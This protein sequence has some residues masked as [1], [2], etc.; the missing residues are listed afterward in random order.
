MNYEVPVQKLRKVCNP[1]EFDFSTTDAVEPLVGIVGQERALRALQLG[2]SMENEGFNIYVVGWPGTGRTGAVMSF[3]DGAAKAKP[4][5]PDW[6]Y[7]HN[8]VDPYYPKAIRLPP[9]QARQFSHDVHA[10]LSEMRV[11]IPLALESEQYTQKHEAVQGAL[12]EQRQAIFAAA[13]QAA[14]RRGFVLQTSPQGVALVPLKN[15]R[16]MTEEEFAALGEEQRREITSRRML[17]ESELGVAMKQDRLAEKRA[18][19]QLQELEREAALSAVRPLVEELKAKYQ[20]STDVVAYLIAVQDSVR[21]NLSAFRVQEQGKPA[22]PDSGA[23]AAALWHRYEVNVMVDNAE[24]Q[25]A[26]VLIELNVT[27]NN[28]FGRIEREAEF[29]SLVTDFTMLK[30]GALHRAN[31]G[32]IV[33]P[34]EGLLANPLAWDGLKRALRSRQIS[35]EDVAEQISAVPVKSV[36]PEPIPLKVKVILIGDPTSYYF[37]QQSDP[38]LA[39]LFKVKAHFDVR[40]ERNPENV[41]AYV[42]FFSAL[43]RKENL[44]PLQRDAAARLIEQGSLLAEDQEQLST[45]FA[46]IADILREA[47]LYARQDNAV[48]VKREHVQRAIDERA[49]RSDALQERIREEMLKGT[50]LIDTDA[51]LVGQVNGLSVLSQG[52]YEFGY[53]TRISATVGQGRDGVL[54]LDREA[55][56]DGPVHTKGV[57]TLGGYLTHKYAHDKPLTLSAHLTFEQSYDEVE[58]DSASSSELYALLS[59]LAELPIRQGIAV[60]GSVN[61]YGQV[62]AIGA[63]N[64]KVEGFFDL[65]KA[66]GLTGRHGVIIPNSNVRNLMLKEELVAAVQNGMFHVYAVENV[67]QGV[68]LLTGVEAGTRGTDGQYP[69]GT[70]HAK[71][72][73]RLR[74]LVKGIERFGKDKT[75]EKDRKRRERSR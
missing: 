74:A 28:L 2:L 20:A 43:C 36:R 23:G 18:G 29:G 41:R 75:D 39:E 3:L 1:Q 47:D 22:T 64:A 58:G 40:M 49:H 71:V 37:L 52:D 72:D 19:E 25:G 4:T 12:N 51:E 35:I 15:G 34:V 38:D 14:Q 44:R 69:A 73:A 55:D 32:Y 66:R 30:A 17:A 8:F 26:P 45:H 62:Q 21:D 11:R 27:Y 10:L 6:C 63:V 24:V 46:W 61:Q 50:V 7:V 70:V 67:D 53:P 54:D 56:L 48:H 59:A 33:L 13:E 31:G 68:S 42:A 65:C 60:T 9:G 5:P 57:L 16:A